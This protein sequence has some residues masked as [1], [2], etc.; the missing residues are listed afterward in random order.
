MKR[1][2]IVMRSGRCMSL[3]VT[4]LSGRVEIGASFFPVAA[5]EGL[6]REHERLVQAVGV[7][8]PRIRMRARLVETLHAAMAAE[9]V[10]RFAGPEPIAGQRLA[11]G[12]QFE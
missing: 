5:V 4:A 7:H 6:A 12:K 11:A 3:A 2:S 8:A 10:L 1:R 9:E